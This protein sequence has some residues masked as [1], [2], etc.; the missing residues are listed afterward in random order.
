IH[1]LCVS[2]LKRYAK[3]KVGEPLKFTVMD[4]D[5]Q[6]NIIAQV[7]EDLCEDLEAKGLPLFAPDERANKAP[8]IR[9]LMN[10]I[11]DAKNENVWAEDYPDSPLYKKHKMASIT[12]PVYTAYQRTCQRLSAFDFDDLLMYTYRL[13]NTNKS[14]L[15]AV[16]NQYQYITVDEYQDT[17]V[18]QND[19][20]NL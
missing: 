15:N 20:V 9:T 10:N 3:G 1:S 13:L 4:S 2:L 16:Q 12:A 8:Y 14:V 11:S 6:K 19:L 17:N 18:L 7:F 5:D